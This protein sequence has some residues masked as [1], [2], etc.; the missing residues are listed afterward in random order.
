MTFNIIDILRNLKSMGMAS[1]DIA[2]I[3]AIVVTMIGLYEVLF[4]RGRFQR[5]ADSHKDHLIDAEKNFINVDKRIQEQ[6]C[7]A[8]E[9]VSS[10]MSNSVERLSAMLENHLKN[11][12]IYVKN[13]DEDKNNMDNYMRDIKDK[14]DEIG[15]NM[16]KY[17][18]SKIKLKAHHLAMIDQEV[19]T[20]CRIGA[21][22]L[23]D[24]LL[25]YKRNN[26]RI[27]VDKLST[28]IA[29]AVHE[30]FDYEYLH[31]ISNG[32]PE[33]A[34]KYCRETDSEIMPDLTIKLQTDI[35]DAIENYDSKEFEKICNLQRKITT[36]YLRDKWLYRFNKKFIID[37]EKMI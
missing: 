20:T 34:I 1:E 23:F 7:A 26:Q 6:F 12:E 8:V 2:V 28:K 14:I 11:F 18:I 10:K 13:A 29:I 21:D 37:E 22:T 16:I 9:K 30:R 32:V 24:G 33:F 4:I 19:T 36:D 27:E 35:K 25:E 17:E 15:T 3:F 31:L 5:T